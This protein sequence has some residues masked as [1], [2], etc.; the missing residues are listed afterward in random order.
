MFL[1]ALFCPSVKTDGNSVKTDG[2]SVVLFR[3]F[4]GFFRV[5]QGSSKGLPRVFQGSS[6]GLTGIKPIE[7]MS[8][9]RMTEEATSYVIRQREKITNLLGIVAVGCHLLLSEEKEFSCFFSFFSA[10]FPFFFA[11]NENSF[12]IIK[13]FTKKM[14][15][16]NLYLLFS[17]FASFIIKSFN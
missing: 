15:F 4:S 16:V 3:C 17:T 2:N 7:I 11:Q 8:R 14:F 13:C 5:F 12:L 10:H 6:K 9:R 1:R